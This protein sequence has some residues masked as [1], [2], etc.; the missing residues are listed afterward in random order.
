MIFLF[1]VPVREGE[2][3]E[4]LVQV[5]MQHVFVSRDPQSF[6][7]GVRV[8]GRVESH[9][10]SMNPFALKVVGKLLEQREKNATRPNLSVCYR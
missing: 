9:Q 4:L 7:H 2:S 5:S 8:K 10:S 1:A 6:G 3:P